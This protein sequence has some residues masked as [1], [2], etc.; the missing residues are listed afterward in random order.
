MEYILS[1]DQ[2]RETIPNLKPG[3]K[4]TIEN[5]IDLYWYNGYK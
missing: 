3:M 5:C 2:L 1:Q 4:M